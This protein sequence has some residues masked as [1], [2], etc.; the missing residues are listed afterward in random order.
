MIY[1]VLSYDGKG[2]Y[3]NESVQYYKWVRV[4]PR[5]VSPGTT[6]FVHFPDHLKSG[7]IY[8][9]TIEGTGTILGYVDGYRVRGLTSQ[10]KE[11]Y[12]QRRQ[13]GNTNGE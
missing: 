13:S 4:Q 1:Y 8:E 6:F 10:E 2:V 11:N 3:R 7:E 5:Q 9:F 12:A